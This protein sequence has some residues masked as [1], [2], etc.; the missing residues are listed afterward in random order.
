MKRGE[1]WRYTG[2]R[3]RDVLIVQSDDFA[4]GIPTV[5]GIPLVPP[6]AAIETLTTVRVSRWI[7]DGTRIGEFRRSSMAERAAVIEVHEMDQL[8]AAMKLALELD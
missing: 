2:L 4:P 5:M 6:G 8:G 3:E 1:V 7:A